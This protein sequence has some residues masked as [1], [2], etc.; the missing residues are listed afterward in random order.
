MQKKEI[1]LTTIIA[2]AA[3]SIAI[4][5]FRKKE[6][7]ATAMYTPRQRVLPAGNIPY[8]RIDSRRIFMKLQNE[9]T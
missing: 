6:I 8:N 5:F 9:P 4:Y 7:S 1:I 2:A 3:V